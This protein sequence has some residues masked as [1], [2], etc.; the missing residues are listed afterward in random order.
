MELGTVI[1]DRYAIE[2]LAGSGGMATVY[3]GLDR[4]NDRVVAIKLLQPESAHMDEYLAREGELLHNLRHPAIVSYHDSGVTSS[5]QRFL[6]MEWLD[7]VDLTVRLR[8]EPLTLAETLTLIGRIASA[9][10]HSHEHHIVHRDVK[11]ANIFLPGR[12][13]RTAKLLDF[14]VARWALGESIVQTSPGARYGTPAYMSPEQVRGVQHLNPRTDIFSLGCVLYEC[15]TGEPAFAA[16][17]AMAV[18]CKILMDQPPSVRDVMPEIPE[19]VEVLLRRMLSKRPANRPNST[20]L[21]R[22]VADI[23]ASLPTTLLNLQPQ[24]QTE[25]EAITD[26]EQRVVHVLIAAV[27]NQF[28]DPI[29]AAAQWLD[30]DKAGAD[31]AQGQA[32]SDTKSGIPTGRLDRL[33]HHLVLLGARFCV[34]DDGSVIAVMDNSNAAA[35]TTITPVDQAIN[36]ARCALLLHEEMPQAIIAITS[37]RAVIHNERL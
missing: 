12:D 29:K 13:V 1:A 19:T 17:D 14:G 4:H 3:R 36:T 32:W 21:I 18:F 11:P 26:T 28:F 10:A 23:A 5:Q 15:L 34:L 27:D 20:R 25:R 33:T 6:V 22:E 9:L 8:E 35:G 31:R 2:A 16:H 37:G 30:S 24:S 7:G